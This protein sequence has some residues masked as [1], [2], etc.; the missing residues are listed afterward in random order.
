VSIKQLA[1]QTL[2]YGVSNIVGRLIGSL[3]S[4][5]LTFL[6]G[7]DA[8][9]MMD[10][11]DFSLLYAWIAVGNI[12]FTYGF[13]TGYFRFVNLPEYN[14]QNVYKTT[15]SSLILST[16]FFC[17]II[18]GLKGPIS[19]GLNMG[20]F[21][22]LIVLVAL[23]LGLDTIATIPFARLRHEG[24]PKMY[25]LVKVSGIVTNL[26]FILFF[27]YVC[28]HKLADQG[29]SWVD[30]I[31]QQHRVFLIVLANLL[32]NILVI[33]LL[34]PN[35][36]GFR[37]QIDKR[38]WSKI[39]RYASPMILIGLAGMVNEVLDR[40]FL[41]WYLPG[42]IEDAKAQIGLYS[43][44]YKIA[45]FISL[46]IQAFRMG[47][48]PFFFKQA[49]K[50]DAPLTY[51]LVMKW[52]TITLCIAFLF[53]S[54]FLDFIVLINNAGYAQG[55][56][57]IPFVLLANVFLGMYYNFSVWYKIT[58]KMIWGSIITILGA[59]VTVGINIWGIPIYGIYAPAVATLICYFSMACLAYF[60][61]QKYY[62]IP[63]QMRRLMTY[64]GLAVVLYLIQRYSYDYWGHLD[65]LYLYKGI[66]GV[67]FI[68]LFML[69][70]LKLERISIKVLI[71]GLQQKLKR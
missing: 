3:L 19:S 33:L 16:I 23:I 51:A 61:G 6:L 49:Q 52:F 62:P 5:I 43:A 68:S 63:Y 71:K 38:L 22:E 37:F 46:F 50:S 70:V 8:R 57:I 2:W 27:L 53:S 56:G 1:G 26:L 32:Q 12:I 15:L 42:S 4:P 25:A 39:F 45:I 66:S 20:D 7:D 29:W 58:N 65:S 48:E 13:E 59:F 28:P 21:P 44:N 11:G 67:V 14:S 30:W 9:G 64:L 35:F 47:A 69:F 54:L 17:A 55:M 41:Q 60:V 18:I 34:L 40:Q 10:M 36:K 24:R 31:N